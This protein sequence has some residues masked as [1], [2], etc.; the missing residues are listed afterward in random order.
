M[1]NSFN[2]NALVQNINYKSIVPVLGNDI[3]VVRLK[4]GSISNFSN[5]N[6]LLEAGQ[7]SEEHF[8]IN[9]YKYIAFRLWDIYGNGTVPYPLTINNV[10]SILQK[11]GTKE[12]E[13]NNYISNS[14]SNLSDEQILLEPY[15]NLIEISGFETFITVNLDNFLK[16]AFNTEKKLNIF[17]FSI[18]ANAVTKE[19]DRSLKEIYNVM[20][21]I[22]G[23]KFALSDE[24][25][26]EYLYKLQDSTDSYV[27]KL[28]E[29][30]NRKNILIIGSSF[31][32]WFMRFFIRSICHES[33][34]DCQRAIYVACDQTCSDIELIKFLNNNSMKIIPIGINKTN[35]SNDYI[36]KN[37]IEFI[38]DL[39][40]QWN[41]Y[42]NKND[43]V[44]RY[45][46]EVF[47]SYSRDDK[48]KAEKLK[49]AFERNGLKVFFD[50][51]ILKT[52]DQFKQ[53]I[54]EHIKSCDY[55]LPV[56]SKNA[57][58]DKSRYVYD[59]EWKIAIASEFLNDRNFIRPFL[60][61]D[62]ALSD[63]RIPEEIRNL[64]ITRITSFNDLSTLVNKFITENNLIPV[65]P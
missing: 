63:T 55:F 31:P 65:T 13:I 33:I 18:P 27:A 44:P 34:R 9:L 61:D 25:A 40:N 50:D 17:N 37:S 6:A 26:L 8:Q 21:N 24:D 12:N 28:F 42:T 22:E 64:N 45:K 2:W 15:K 3:S 14:I 11:N 35:L 60:I 62:T 57:I 41:K 52:G 30:L 19:E 36:Y 20:G 23:T 32:D 48:D 51:D 47:I 10:K 59:Q 38:N 16:R 54:K 53:V 4:K 56:I 5:Y 49:N 58:E 29:A 39:F 7:E 46:E 1:S 43:V